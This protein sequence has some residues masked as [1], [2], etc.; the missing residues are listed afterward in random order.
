MKQFIITLFAVILISCNT[1][2][3]I[4]GLCADKFIIKDSIVF[5]DRFDTIFE[6]HQIDTMYL[7]NN[8][9]IFDTIK[10][11][12]IKSINKY[13]DKIIYRENTAKVDIL[14]NKLKDI[15]KVNNQ[16][17]QEVMKMKEQIKVYKILRNMFFALVLLSIFFYI[18]LKTISK[19]WL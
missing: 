16:Q 5:I 3:K 13:Q 18:Y 7:W 1:E 6:P 4:I 9:Y 15:E 14:N 17:Q 12:T 19:K 2:K 10:L 11:K 8:K